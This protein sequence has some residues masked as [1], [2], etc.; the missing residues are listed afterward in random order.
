[1]VCVDPKILT[2]ERNLKGGENKEKD[3]VIG[4]YVVDMSKFVKGIEKNDEYNI[5]DEDI[6]L[7]ADEFDEPTRFNK[8]NFAI[9]LVAIFCL[10]LIP[11]LIT[12][13]SVKIINFFAIII[14]FLLT[15][16]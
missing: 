7:A 15:A 8:R 12:I 1:M 3:G 6:V 9:G 4:R 2:S 13:L 10:C 16:A 5:G 14:S 11:V